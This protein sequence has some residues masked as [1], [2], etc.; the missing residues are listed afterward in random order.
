MFYM[1]FPDEYIW[2]YPDF[3]SL[4]VTYGN[5]NNFFFPATIAL[6]TINTLESWEL[7]NRYA[8]IF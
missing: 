2:E 4:I 8:A 7:N 1:A 5:Q 3:Y 6:G